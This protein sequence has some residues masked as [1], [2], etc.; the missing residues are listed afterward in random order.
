MSMTPEIVTKKL[1]KLYPDQIRT[2]KYSEK[3]DFNL[4]EDYGDLSDVASMLTVGQQTPIKVTKTKDV[5][6]DGYPVYELEDGHRRHKYMLMQMKKAKP[7]ADLEKFMLLAEELPAKTDEKQLTLIMMATGQGNKQLS[8]YEFAKG[9][10]RLMGMGMKKADIAR[11]LGKTPSHIDDCE[12]LM[13]A[14]AKYLKQV[15]EGA[16]AATTVIAMVK[17]GTFKDQ[18]ED[19]D[20][21]DAINEAKA[22]GKSKA[23][24]GDVKKKKGGVSNNGNK[25]G[26]DDYDYDAPVNGKMQPAIEDLESLKSMLEEQPEARNEKQF[27]LLETIIGYLKGTKDAV[28]IGALMFDVEAPA[29]SKKGD[30][31]QAPADKKSLKQFIDEEKEKETQAKGKGK[32]SAAKLPQEDDPTEL[33][34]EE[35][36]PAPK[37][38]AAKKSKKAPEPEPEE[39]EEAE[40]LDEV[41]EDDDFETEEEDDENEDFDDDEDIDEDEEEE[42]DDDDF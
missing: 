2:K 28:D 13:S 26:A 5:T 32:K 20:V 4:R 21:D 33:D 24:I 6:E 22:K 25:K 30:N 14:P 29:K 34:T 9:V 36:I 15:S 1:L 10:K 16:I 8:L 38:K 42:D 12:K 19:E 35:E 40:E 39:E 3:E 23:T 27:E 41:V 17:E 18:E 11:E 31:K 7:D 37:A